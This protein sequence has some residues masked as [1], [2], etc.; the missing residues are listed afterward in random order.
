MQNDFSRK[1]HH[2]IAALKV[3]NKTIFLPIFSKQKSVQLRQEYW[4]LFTMSVFETFFA[5]TQCNTLVITDV[6]FLGVSGDIQ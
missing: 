5:L 1:L 6:E 4:V 3:Y 2:A